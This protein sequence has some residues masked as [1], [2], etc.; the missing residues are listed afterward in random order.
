MFREECVG[1]FKC[2]V[3]LKKIPEPNTETMP[4][5]PFR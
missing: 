5:K 4:T 2:R 1:N 3:S